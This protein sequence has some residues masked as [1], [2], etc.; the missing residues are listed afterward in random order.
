MAV[1]LAHL[2]KIETD[3]LRKYVIANLLRKIKVMEYLPF[4]TVDSLKSVAVRW[5]TL[6]DVA[7]RAINRGYT[8]SEGDTE[9]VWEAVYALGGEI[10]YDR[11]FEKIGNT[12]VDMKQMQTDMKLM[13]IALKFNEYFINGD[14]ASDGYGF[15]GLKKRI[16]N[17][18]SRQLVG[19]AGAAAAA[20]DPTASTAIA[21][22]FFNGLEEMHYKTNQGQVNAIFCN[23]GLY[24]GIG[25]VARYVQ[26][27]GGNFLD[28]TKD[29]FD[30]QI[31]TWKGA[32]LIDIGLKKDQSTEIITE[33]EV[34]GDAGADASSLYMAS[35]NE[36]QGIIGIELPPGLEAYDPLN[37]G[38]Q[39]S[40]PTKLL[41]CEWW[42]GLA[43]FGSYGFT[44]GWNVE[45]AA[46]WT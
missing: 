37:G 18:P 2:A 11:V 34:A 16:T 9:Q 13:S 39:E 15:E 24:Y 28:V 44:R 43:G 19:F 10:K 22:A 33:T 23:E 36:E 25:K 21:N 45:G 26:A 1:T 32:P 35:F 40:T 12:I 41:R 20:L 8:P 17:M 46:N 6:P 38:E 7:F 42:L 27:S 29:S 4:T 5:Q 30:R 31:T 3:V 14:H